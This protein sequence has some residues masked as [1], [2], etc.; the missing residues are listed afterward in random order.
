MESI[1]SLRKPRSFEILFIICFALFATV[2]DAANEF[3]ISNEF[4]YTFNDVSGP[5][6]D[7][8]SLT[9]GWRYLNVFGLTGNG[10]V[11]GWDYN[12]NLGVKATD[13]R[14]NDVATWS[15]TNFQ[16]RMTNK[17][18]TITGGDTFESF[19]QYSLSTALKGGSYKYFDEQKNSPELTFVYGYAFPRW[20]NIYGGQDTRAITREA[21][22]MKI[23]QNFTP[24]L[25]AGASLVSANDLSRTRVFTT[26]PIY[27]ST[28]YTFDGEYRPI[29]GLTVKGELSFS[30]TNLSPQENADVQRMHGSAYRVE[31][32]GDGGPSRVSIEYE[33]VA[34]EFVSILGSATPDREKA[35]ARWRYKISKNMDLNT[36]MLWYRDNLDGQKA[37]RTD[38]Y[39]P[40][41]SLTMR[42]V[43]NRPYS[44]V[45]V[46]YKYDRKL[47]GSAFAGAPSQADH[48]VTLGYRDR[49]WV[50]D[51]DAN[52]G[53]SFYNTERNQR[54]SREYIYNVSLTSR[55][56][57]DEYVLKPML[58]MGG[59]TIRD[60]LATNTDRIY[61]YSA[62]MGIEI[63]K[64]KI[65]SDAKVGQ[66]V[67]EKTAFGTDN[68]AKTFAN[69]NIYYKPALHAR[70]NTA[71]FYIRAFMNDFRYSTITN[72]FRENSVTLGMNLQF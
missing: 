40:D 49:F 61:E 9:K 59:V 17:I 35:K 43:F 65:T 24:T 67:L 28:N 29:P 51:S 19:S 36:G 60:D 26:D 68:S 50:I 22:G 30:R 15:L 54:D 66:N 62:G 47:G 6:S 34:T 69:F 12:L 33:K 41:A 63:P 20:D 42:N 31:A 5:G 3:H 13:D 38:S 44:S 7:N 8:S 25:S 21:Y 10:S 64:W 57:F 52:F 56:Q 46:G 71:M 18:H 4:G 39:T 48:I 45:D 58:Y 53:Y 72:N 16:G 14:R 55:H 37:Y 11:R 1:R 70:L 23:K 27:D 2:A 32:V